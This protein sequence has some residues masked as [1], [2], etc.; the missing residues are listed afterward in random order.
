MTDPES[1]IQLRRRFVDSQETLTKEW[2]IRL[3]N[4]PRKGAA[5]IL[6]MVERRRRL[7]RKE[8]QR[9]RKML[10]HEKAWWDQGTTHVAGVDEAGV[11]PLAGPVVAA[12][13][14]LPMSARWRGVDDSKKLTAERRAQLAE[15]IK[16][17]AIA[18]AVGS[19]APKEIDSINV[20]HASLLAM[21]RAVKGL[22]VPPAALLV[23]ARHVPNMT[24][25]QESLIKGDARSL[26]IAAASII[27]KTTRDALMIEMDE[28][29]P[30]YGFAQ[31]KGYPVA[32]H[33]AA[34]KRLG[35]SPIHR[36]SFAAVRELLTP[37]LTLGLNMTP[38]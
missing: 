31:H 7:N 27:A 14:I 28:T 25:P 3:R 24:L 35:P 37:Q 29:Y 30:G 38:E 6:R 16:T 4:D 34:L 33:K 20:Y 12:A 26:S 9:L 13:V 32:A 21:E 22:S 5:T 11:S 19:V 8:G 1:L 18:W 23:D 10:Q 36:T 17:R 2:E 15:K